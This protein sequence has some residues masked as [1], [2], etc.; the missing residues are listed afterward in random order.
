MSSCAGLKRNIL[1]CFGPVGAKE[2]IVST[3]RSCDLKSD[4]GH[5]VVRVARVDVKGDHEVSVVVVVWIGADD[6]CLGEGSYFC[7]GGGFDMFLF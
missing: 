7:V 1:C 4:V 5:V 2:S 3:G 6:G